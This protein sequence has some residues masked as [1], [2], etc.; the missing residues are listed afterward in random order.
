MRCS[1]SALR[2]YLIH[3]QLRSVVGPLRGSLGRA[4]AFVAQKIYQGPERWPHLAAARIIMKKSCH[5]SWRPL[6][7]NRRKSA[8]GKI[9]CDGNGRLL[10]EPKAFDSGTTSTELTTNRPEHRAFYRRVFGHR[11][12]SEPR[13]YP[14]LRKPICLITLDYPLARL[15]LRLRAGGLDACVYCP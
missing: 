9:R 3:S 7:E 11:L 6:V 14:L 2:E 13:H 8:F 10:Y 1:K 15:I 12:A 4:T 5:R